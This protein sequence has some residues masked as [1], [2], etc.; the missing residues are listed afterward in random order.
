MLCVIHSD[1]MVTWNEFEAGEVP[2]IYKAKKPFEFKK[3]MAV[4]SK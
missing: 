1:Q 4:F 3:Q 2:A